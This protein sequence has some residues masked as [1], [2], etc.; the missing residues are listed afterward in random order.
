M[1]VQKK[2]KKNLLYEI[3]LFMMVNLHRAILPFRINNQLPQKKKKKR[4]SNQLI[5]FLFDD[6]LNQSADS[7]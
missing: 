3:M 4:I 7:F 1:K 6:F 2:K 5:F